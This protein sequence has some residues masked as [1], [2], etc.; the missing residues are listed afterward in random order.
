MVLSCQVLFPPLRC[1]LFRLYPH[2]VRDTE[3][4]I[5]GLGFKAGVF[6]AFDDQAG[7]ALA[8]DWIASP[9]AQKRADGV[10]ALLFRKGSIDVADVRVLLADKAVAGKVGFLSSGYEVVTIAASAVLKHWGADSKQ[11]EG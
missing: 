7:T 4:E 3:A 8:R 2:L 5:D 1:A 11:P 9:D 10:R 6:I